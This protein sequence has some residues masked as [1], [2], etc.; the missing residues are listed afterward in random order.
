M[1]LKSSIELVPFSVRSKVEQG[2]AMIEK[3]LAGQAVKKSDFSTERKL[4]ILKP[5]FLDLR[6]RPGCSGL[7]P[8]AHFCCGVPPGPKEK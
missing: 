1:S 2:R 4:Y 6:H 7:V 8:R 3:H 5:R